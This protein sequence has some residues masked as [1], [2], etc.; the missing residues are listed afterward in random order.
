MDLDSG[1]VTQTDSSLINQ[2]HLDLAPT[3]PGWNIHRVVTQVALSSS[4]E[5]QLCGRKG[6][7]RKLVLENQLLRI[8]DTQATRSDRRQAPK[9]NHF[10]VPHEFGCTLHVATWP[11]GGQ[12]FHDS[13][14][15][16][17][18]K[19][20]DA[21]LAEVTLVLSDGEVAGWTSDG[22][23]C[24]PQFFLPEGRTSDP[25]IVYQRLEQILSLL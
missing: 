3:L 21:S 14:G 22:H 6:Q 9:L 12:V 24:G 11:G 1:E 2:Q 4:R 19:S 15:M 13:R 20:Q 16:L 5:L 25:E 10:P 8:R 17:H 23:W 7:W 18:F